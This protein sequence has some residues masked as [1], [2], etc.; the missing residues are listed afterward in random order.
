M[1]LQ[2]VTVALMIEAIL[3]LCVLLG[4]MTYRWRKRIPRDQGA[5]GFDLDGFLVALEASSTEIQDSLEGFSEED[6]LSIDQ[7]LLKS[8]EEVCIDFLQILA[9]LLRREE[10]GQDV[11][12]SDSMTQGLRK[13][14]DLRF[15]GL[16]VV[17]ES[18]D[19]PPTEAVAEDDKQEGIEETSVEV[20]QN[21]PPQPQD[22]EEEGRL[23]VSL[24]ER[25]DE[26]RS[27]TMQIRERVESTEEV[28]EEKAPLA[29]LLEHIGTTEGFFKDVEPLHR[30]IS[31]CYETM[32]RSS[33]EL[34]GKFK[35]LQLVVQRMQHA[36]PLY[37][38][39]KEVL[40]DL[41]GAS[42]PA[43]A[44]EENATAQAD[45]GTIS[46]DDIDALLGGDATAA[47][48]PADVPEENAT[49]QADGGTI[50]Q[51]DIDALLGGDATVASSPA[52]VPEENAAEQ[53]DESTKN[54]S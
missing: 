33:E 47:S 16:K 36:G 39:E 24:K 10:S 5:T 35:K 46:Q 49:A 7:L 43:D 15:R 20:A 17:L 22:C 14:A 38:E 52:D 28:I 51:D 32:K 13:A 41:Q 3:L 8:Q 26:F 21:E 23:F 9:D 44:P 48:S 50:S 11:T 29:I 45:G 12:V 31:M 34:E 42:S 1:I 30:E 53:A 54:P 19:V 40:E 18:E 4:Y 37:P 6:A 25:M 2:P 27:Q